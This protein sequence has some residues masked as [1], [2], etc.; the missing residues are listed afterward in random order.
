MTGSRRRGTPTR[1]AKA[2]QCIYIFLYVHTYIHIYIRCTKRSTQR[3]SL[4]PAG[5]RSI[6]SGPSDPAAHAPSSLLDSSGSTTPTGGLRN[7]RSEGGAPESHGRGDRER[8]ERRKRA[9]RGATESGGRGDRELG[10][11]RQRAT[12]S[13][14]TPSA[15][16]RTHTLKH[17]HTTHARTHARTHA[18]ATRPCAQTHARTHARASAL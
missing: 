4:I 10:E 15:R 1:P 6:S 12:A 7:R 9:S 8:R 14:G 18:S 2:A 11:G 17:T 16:T 13:P 3:Q 5:A